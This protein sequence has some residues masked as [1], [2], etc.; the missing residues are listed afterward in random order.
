MRA[1]QFHCFPPVTM[2]II[3]P[4]LP[5]RREPSVRFFRPP[6]E[7][8]DPATFTKT[9]GSRLRGNDEVVSSDGASLVAVSYADDRVRMLALL[10]SGDA[11][12]ADARCQRGAA[13]RSSGGG[14]CRSLT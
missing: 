6:R 9:L 14:G 12:I 10:G 13:A 1:Q 4:S 7:G 8:E 2:L 11:H 5:R 3:V